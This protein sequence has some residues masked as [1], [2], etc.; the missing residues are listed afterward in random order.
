[1]NPST[2]R[3]GVGPSRGCVPS[4]AVMS[5]DPGK[6]HFAWARFTVVLEHLK[7]APGGFSSCGVERW[8]SHLEMLQCF[9]RVLR[10]AGDVLVIEKM[11]VYPGPRPED[12][13]DL[14]DVTLTAGALSA[15]F[16]FVYHVPAFSW[17]G[18]VPKEVTAGRVV[19]TLGF[20][21]G[22]S[23]LARDRGHVYDAIGI[24]LWARG[25]YK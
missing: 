16:P 23:M 9:D 14:I 18:Q 21:P 8:S 10:G 24:G 15:K 11:R 3:V 4:V 25:L 7:Q 20:D 19:A 12:P 1:M 13:N 5:V 2:P 17:K 6:D 22:A